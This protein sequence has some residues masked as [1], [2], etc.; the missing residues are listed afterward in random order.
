MYGFQ[1]L[2][3]PFSGPYETDELFFKGLSW[4]RPIIHELGYGASILCQ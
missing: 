3:L 4:D 1:K 2:G